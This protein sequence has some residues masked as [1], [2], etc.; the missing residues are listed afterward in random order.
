M[1]CAGAIESPKLL[2]LSGAIAQVQ[3]RPRLH[4]R[5]LTLCP[6]PTDPVGQ[7]WPGGNV[8]PRRLT[9]NMWVH[10]VCTSGVALCCVC[11]HVGHNGAC[12]RELAHES[13]AFGDAALHVD[14]HAP[15][16]GRIA[17]GCPKSPQMAPK[18]AVTRGI[19]GGRERAGGVRCGGEKRA[20]KKGRGRGRDRKR[21]R[22]RREESL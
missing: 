18:W 17:S 9:A 16:M 1:L 3:T 21:E 15:T 5:L 22:E 4:Y 12:R 2:L 19:M 13:T 20:R 6:A 10:M 11:G 8:E 7:S 14:I